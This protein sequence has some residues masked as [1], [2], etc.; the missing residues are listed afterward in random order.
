[1]VLIRE[2]SSRNADREP[3]KCTRAEDHPPADK[4]ACWWRYFCFRS[5]RID[6][7]DPKL[8]TPTGRQCGGPNE[9]HP[10]TALTW[11]KGRFIKCILT[12]PWNNDGTKTEMYFLACSEKGVQ[13]YPVPKPAVFDWIRYDLRPETVDLYASVDGKTWQK[14]AS[15]PR[16]AEA[17]KDFAGAPAHLVLG[18]GCDGPNDRLRNDNDGIDDSYSYYDEWVVETL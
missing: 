8:Y 13:T 10:M 14:V 12:N 1:M 11:G 7:N 17:G 15:V 6:P 9:T 16:G 3:D 2:S 5:D 18:V 4:N